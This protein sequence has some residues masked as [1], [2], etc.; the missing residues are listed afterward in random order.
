MKVIDL[1]R[2]IRFHGH[3]FLYGFCNYLFLKLCRPFVNYTFIYS[4]N[5]Y[6]LTCKI[7][8]LFVHVDGR[9]NDILLD[10]HI[11]KHCLK[12]DKR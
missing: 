11:D 6:R 5:T 7:K 9:E 10:I 1:S 3:F 2:A 4:Q 8:I 12:K